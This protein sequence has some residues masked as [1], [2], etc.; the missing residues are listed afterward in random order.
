MPDLVEKICLCHEALERASVPH[1]FGGAL[2]LAWC[3]EQAR[4]TIDIDI[5]LLV[6]ADGIEMSLAAL[7]DDIVWRAA[8]VKRLHSELQHRLWWGETPV[9]LFYNSTPYHD[10]LI[11]RVRVEEFAGRQIPFLSCVDLA[12]FKAFFNRT[13]DWADL[14]AMHD[15]GTLDYAH[16]GAT[17]I[18]LLGPDEPRLQRLYS[19]K[20]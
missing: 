15:A 11:E 12:V 10:R 8:D 18:D 17:L 14:E 9:D 7:P 13:K 5:N 19:L 6:G 20:S 16:V 2:A 4:G 1:A 3:T